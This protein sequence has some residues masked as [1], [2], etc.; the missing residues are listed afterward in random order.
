MKWEEEKTLIC[1]KALQITCLCFALDSAT[2]V[3]VY[4]G[5]V[6]TKMR[7]AG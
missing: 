1:D 3:M 2:V 4:L 6:H 5:F 7:H